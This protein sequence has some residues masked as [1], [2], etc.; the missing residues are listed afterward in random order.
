MHL[1]A[2]HP[3]IVTARMYPFEARAGRY[4][5]QVLQVLAEPSNALQSS[6][7]DGTSPNPWWVGHHPFYRPPFVD[8]PGVNRWFGRSYVEQVAG[9]CLR[10]TDGFYR[11]VA[12]SQGKSDPAYFAEKHQPDRSPGLLRELYPA[13]REVLLIRDFRDMVCSIQAFNARRGTSDFGRALVKSEEE[14]LSLVGQRARD[15]ARH[16]KSRTDRAHLLRYEDLIARPTDAIGALLDFLELERTLETIAKMIHDASSDANEFQ[17]HGT[18]VDPASSVGR[19][20]VDLDAP[21][22]EAVEREF[23][24]VLGA[25]GY[26]VSDS[27]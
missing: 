17:R 11:K 21:M 13:A 4:W 9:F 22:K 23:A 8:D 14:Y 12:Q 25:F 26:V 19:W 20:K 27:P 7:P 5:M 3:R 24:E 16:W 18:S 6:N 15:L 10:S 1:L 2:E